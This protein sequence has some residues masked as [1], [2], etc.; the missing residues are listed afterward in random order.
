MAKNDKDR[1]IGRSKSQTLLRRSGLF[2]KTGGY[3]AAPAV[4]QCL[5]P[6]DATLAEIQALVPRVNAVPVMTDDSQTA[7]HTLTGSGG[8]DLICAPTSIPPG[9]ITV[10]FSSG[11]K[12][13][14][15]EY[16]MPAAATPAP[17]GDI[18]D[19]YL[20]LFYANN[21]AVGLVHI[22][23]V[24]AISSNMPVTRMVVERLG[25][26][27]SSNIEVPASGRFFVR[28]DADTGTFS[29]THDM[30]G[31]IA[32]SDDSY[33]P[34]EPCIFSVNLYEFQSAGPSNAGKD[35]VIRLITN[36]EDMTGTYPAGT[37]DICG[38][39]L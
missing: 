34:A 23:I 5:Y 4:I 20:G 15:W 38:T 16:S 3:S 17:N 21:F 1:L 31:P 6:M 7:T 2:R 37:T 11:F 18:C 26:W 36:A 14:E 30:L 27:V 13:F 24:S 8:W 28:L 9:P 35:M 29:V 25:S 10:D 22:Y 12:A 19:A 32:L 33:N 39:P